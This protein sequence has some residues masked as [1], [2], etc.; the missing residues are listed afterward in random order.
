MIDGGLPMPELKW[1]TEVIGHITVEGAQRSGLPEGI[2]VAAGTMDSFADAMSV[3][4]RKPGDAVVIYGS[5]MSIV[6]VTDE[7]LP[8]AQ[9]WSNAHLFENKIGRAHV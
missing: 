7:S 3:G 1:P 2:P 4:V 5:T 6:L 9:L 8:S